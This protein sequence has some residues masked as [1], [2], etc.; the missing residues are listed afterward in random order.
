[1]LPQ[2]TAA[3]YERRAVKSHK[4]KKEGAQRHEA[5]FVALCMHTLSA[6]AGRWCG[7][8]EEQ[9]PQA[10]VLGDSARQGCDREECKLGDVV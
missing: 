9:A 10:T 2:A 6:G 3:F 4:T 1:M 7:Q 5:N 8:A